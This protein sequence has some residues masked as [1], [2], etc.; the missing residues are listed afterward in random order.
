MSAQFEGFGA[1][2]P[3]SKSFF[4]NLIGKVGGL[5]GNATPGD[6]VK[7]TPLWS[8]DFV[9][10]VG[11][12]VPEL[13]PNPTETVPVCPDPNVPVTVAVPFELL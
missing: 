12:T 8:A 11:L 5:S 4:G 6:N 2:P 10:L 1:N 9:A 3:E 7:V 13:T